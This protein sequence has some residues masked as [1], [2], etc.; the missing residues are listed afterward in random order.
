MVAAHSDSR[1]PWFL[2]AQRRDTNQDFENI[3]DTHDGTVLLIIHKGIALVC[4]Y[5]GD[6]VFVANG[7]CTLALQVLH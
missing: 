5:L 7:T 2:T 6:V 3:T 1:R 4:E